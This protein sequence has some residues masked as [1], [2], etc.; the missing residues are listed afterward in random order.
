MTNYNLEISVMSG[1][2]L[3]ER[4]IKQTKIIVLSVE[5]QGSWAIALAMCPLCV[6]TL[7]GKSTRKVKAA[8][9]A[10][11][12]LSSHIKYAHQTTINDFVFNQSWKPQIAGLSEQLETMIK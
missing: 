11:E 10:L 6:S 8:E 5:V 9:G 2:S 1:G 3:V 4:E 7:D 12:K